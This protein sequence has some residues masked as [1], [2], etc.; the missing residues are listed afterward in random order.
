M[1]ILVTGGAGFIGSHVVDRLLDEGHEVTV[2]DLW[3]SDEAKVH[4]D[5]PNYKFVVG[6]VLNDELMN[7]LVSGKDRVIHMAA[8]LGTSETITT[9][10]VEQVAEVNVVGTVKM[11]KLCKKYGVGRVLIPTTPDVTWLN[12]YKITKAAIEKFAQLFSENYGVEAVCM[13]LGNIY[14]SRERW[15]DGPKEAPYNYQKV[16]P[17]ILMETLKGNQFNVYG[18]GNQKSEYIYVGDVAESFY[19]AL[20]SEKDLGGKVIHVGRDK[21]NSVNEIID[22]V[23]EAWGRKVDRNYVDMRPGEHH[24]EITLDPTLLKELLDY[25]L[26]WDL[27]E[28]LKETIEY[29]EKAYSE[30]Y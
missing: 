2:L 20:T 21:N 24:V 28:G 5:N 13:K 16:I 7:E 30:L 1:R 4:S 12:P 10:D 17:T 8:V 14:G 6:N 25:E 15:L 3:E 27:P 18:N 29:Y 9:Y 22:A 19:R 26:Q 23:E 11:L